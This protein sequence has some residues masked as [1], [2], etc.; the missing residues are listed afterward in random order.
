MYFFNL[1]YILTDVFL[2]FERVSSLTEEFQIIRKSSQISDQICVTYVTKKPASGSGS[3]CIRTLL[4]LLD[5]DQ[6]LYC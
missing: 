1:L 2:S 5:P 3:D 4:A 6:Y